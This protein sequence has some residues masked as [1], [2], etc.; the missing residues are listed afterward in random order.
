MRHSSILALWLA[1]LPPSS[2]MGQQADLARTCHDASAKFSDAQVAA[3][4]TLTAR[5]PPDY[6]GVMVT[7][8]QLSIDSTSLPDAL[9]LLHRGQQFF[10]DSISLWQIEAGLITV[11]VGLASTRDTLLHRA[12]T[13]TDS[14]RALFVLSHLATGDTAA[15]LLQ[16]ALERY[17]TYGPALREAFH[18]WYC[19][20]YCRDESADSIED[21]H[22]RRL[23]NAEHGL[24]LIQRSDSVWTAD[25]YETAADMADTLGR[26]GLALEYARRA[27]ALADSERFELPTVGSEAPDPSLSW[28]P[29]LK[30]GVDLVSRLQ[31][32]GES[33]EAR[34]L[35]RRILSWSDSGYTQSD[36]FEIWDLLEQRWRAGDRY[37]VRQY[38]FALVD[39]ENPAAG[40]GLLRLD[41]WLADESAPGLLSDSRISV[42]REFNRRF[43]D[44]CEGHLYLG[45]GLR[46]A[47]RLEESRRSLEDAV[48]CAPTWA[49]AWGEYG[50]AFYLQGKFKLADAAWERGLLLNPR[51][52]DLSGWSAAF[53]DAVARVGRQA[54]M[55]VPGA[56]PRSSPGSAAHNA[57]KAPLRPV[58]TGSAFVINAQGQLLTNAHVVKGCT[59]IRTY[60]AGQPVPATI[61]VQDRAN[62]LAVISTGRRASHRV[63][64]RD[65][66]AQTGEDAIAAGYPLRGLLADQ[67]N[68]TTGNVSSLAGPGADSRL[69]QV[70]NAVA[71]GNSGG[72]L[73]DASGRVI[74]MVSAKLDAVEAFQL[75]GD[76]STNISF[77][78]N[79]QVIRT[80]LR[81][82]GVSALTAGP[83]VPRPTTAVADLARQVTVPV[84]CMR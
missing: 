29:R 27:F 76:L 68:V 45:L 17:P 77:A 65:T 11:R 24:A 52:F 69:L 63:I 12:Q 44:R 50:G 26:P 54:P 67:L 6:V 71:P 37:D 31:A 18:K 5:T 72:P 39:R 19:M 73:F 59:A 49:W 82:N 64:F 20:K 32:V 38:I 15:G 7:A 60:I 25:D 41:G 57:A 79:A 1:L 9:R 74:G 10:P 84:E 46:A 81:V 56:A 42:W 75:S 51:L 3:C 78:I 61:T 30:V 43:P 2:A 21:A 34:E 55:A 83:A 13:G 16:E 33:G 70:T 40:E 35:T 8:L 23:M 66:P 48:R 22:E 58:G 4:R 53:N 80:F 47:Q 28:L 62:D 36:W 14:A